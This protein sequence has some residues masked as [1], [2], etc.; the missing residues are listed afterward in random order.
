MTR[1]AVCL[2][3]LALAAL[4]AGARAQ[5]TIDTLAMRAH[6]YFLSHDRLLGRATGTTEAEIAALYLASRCRALGLRPVA[7]DYFQPVQLEAARVL[8]DTRLSLTIGTDTIRFSYPADFVP[9]VGRN[10]TL[11]SFAGW[12]VYVGSTGDILAGGASTLELERRVAV[13]LGPVTGAAADSLRARGAMA[14]I[15]LIDDA[16]RYRL[17]VQS[18]GAERLYH[19]D[20]DVSS[21]SLPSLPSLIAAPQLG[22]TMLT[23]LSALA[24]EPS[25]PQPLRLHASLEITL[26][27]R[28]LSAP[29]IACVLPGADPEARDT[30]IVFAAHYDHLGVSTPDAAGDSIYNGFSDNAAGAAMLLAIAQA[31]LEDDADPPRHSMLFL[32]FTGEE[33]GLLGS[34]YYVARPLWPLARTAAVINLDAGAPPAPPASWQLAGADSSRLGRIAIRV[35]TGRGWLVT[36]SAPRPISDFYPFAREGVPAMLIIPGAAPY[37]GLSGDSSA[38]LRQR[39]DRYHQPSDEWAPDFP[40]AGMARYAEYAYLIAR[41]VDSTSIQ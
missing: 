41:A 27:R 3:L 10:T 18:R 29:N 26:E 21:S 11:V 16:N 20:P 19:R 14:M 35:A 23:R 36:T 13:T 22:R 7:N 17:Y 39:W 9:N 34:D 12:A 40:F 37:E 28:A 32:F 30:A 1:R 5:V 2:S 15:H 33:R 25:A 24:G 6:T 31:M 8:P 4:G 38:A